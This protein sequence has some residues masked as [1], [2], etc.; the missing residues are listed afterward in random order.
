MSQEELAEKAGMS[1]SF[2][3]AIEAPGLAKAFSVKILNN[4][5]DALEV[6]PWELLKA[7]AST[8]EIFK[9]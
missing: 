8:S 3:S 6:E 7:S 4:L 9:K 2:L 5:A 1:R